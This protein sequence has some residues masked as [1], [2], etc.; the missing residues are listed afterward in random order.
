MCSKGSNKN[1]SVTSRSVMQREISQDATAKL[2]EERRRR[3]DHILQIGEWN[4]SYVEKT[5]LCLV[6]Q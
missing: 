1:Y 6:V 5:Y 2:G 4:G 3:Y